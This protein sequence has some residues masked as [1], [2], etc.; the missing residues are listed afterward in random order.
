MRPFEVSEVQITHREEK[1]L[2]KC[3]DLHN[4][5]LCYNDDEFPDEI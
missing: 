3:N 4:Y 1:L 2:L 5:S